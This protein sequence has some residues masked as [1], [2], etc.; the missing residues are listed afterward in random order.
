MQ[1]RTL[2]HATLALSESSSSDPILITDPWLFGSCYWRSWWLANP[3]TDKEID[4]LSRTQYIYLTHEHQDHLHIPSLRRIGASPTYL[5]PDFLR[6]EMDT[7]L[8]EQM[9]Y[10]VQ[11]LPSNK[12][13]RLDKQLQVL[14]LIY[15][16]NDSVLLVDT[17]TALL[18]NLND[19]KPVRGF[20]DA[21][22][23]MTR[24]LSKP[25]VVLRSY[26]LAGP[27]YSFFLDGKRTSKKTTK[28]YV[29]A[30]YGQAIRV[31]GDY[32]VPFASQVVFRRSDT[33]WA[34]AIRVD[35]NTLREHWR[36]GPRLLPPYITLD[37]E[38]MTF[39][40]PDP[41]LSA[42]PEFKEHQRALVHKQEALEAPA[43]L[44]QEELSA[45]TDILNEERLTILFLCPRGL[46]LRLGKNQYVYDPLRGML[47]EGDEGKT[48]NIV[49]PTDAVKG[50][51]IS[52]HISDL[53]IGLFAQI[54]IDHEKRIPQFEAL[55][56]ILL[57]RD[58]NY[59]GM[60]K[61]L[62]WAFWAMRLIRPKVIPPSQ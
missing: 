5:V 16:S 11:R 23:A 47:T 25:R 29:G 59:G 50:A 55:Y 35:Y 3:P 14:C 51:L 44:D 48:V 26:S 60:F 42:D 9:G 56:R 4:W 19:V 58:N 8:A 12:W 39:V 62:R 24:T 40:A 20:L 38:K 28:G 46:A 31:G 2:G 6:M 49:L 33:Q 43:V 53:F 54:T 13:V 10:H 17:P 30:A 34:N 32:F 61:R 18:I 57:L 52:R 45:L 27:A 15:P 22:G 1:L 41:S 37:L 21:I 7:Y 36:E